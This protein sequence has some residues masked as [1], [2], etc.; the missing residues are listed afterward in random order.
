[1]EAASTALDRSMNV[2]RGIGDFTINTAT[3]LTD[4]NVTIP[5]GCPAIVALGENSNGLSTLRKFRD[6]VLSKTPAG[7][8]LIRLYYEWSPSIVKEMEGDEKFKEEVKEMIDR[9]LPLV[10]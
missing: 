8:E 6:E 5:T 9:V 3:E 1:M 10:R 2:Q 4:Y 7:Q